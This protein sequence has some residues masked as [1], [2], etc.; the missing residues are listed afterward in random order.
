MNAQQRALSTAYARH[1]QSQ[2]NLLRNAMHRGIGAA[3]IAGAGLAAHYG[4]LPAGGASKR[5]RTDD[6]D[7]PDLEEFGR[8]SQDSQVP[9]SQGLP[10]LGSLGSL[11]QNQVSQAG[12]GGGGD[13]GTPGGGSNQGAGPAPNTQ[14]SYNEGSNTFTYRH[15]GSFHISD[16]GQHNTWTPVPWEFPRLWIQNEEI[17]EAWKNYRYYRTKSVTIKFKNP[18]QRYR[19]TQATG[20]INTHSDPNAR[21]LVAYDEGCNHGVPFFTD[22]QEEDWNAFRRA[23]QFGGFDRNTNSAY[24]L[25]KAV[26]LDSLQANQEMMRYPLSDF[27]AGC[28]EIQVGLGQI[29]SKTYTPTE[30]SWRSIE[31]L[32]HSP[33]F[34]YNNAGVRQALVSPQDLLNDVVYLGQATTTYLIPWRADNYGCWRYNTAATGPTGNADNDD[35]PVWSMYR[36]DFAQGMSSINSTT[37]VPQYYTKFYYPIP[38]LLNQGMI[39]G[40]GNPSY[41][42]RLLAN[43]CEEEEPQPML[44]VSYR[45]MITNDGTS[46]MDQKILLDFEYEWTIECSGK[47]FPK[48][49]TM[50]NMTHNDNLPPQ[51]DQDS[52]TP[53]CTFKHHPT[54]LGTTKWLAYPEYPIFAMMNAADRSSANNWEA[55]MPGGTKCWRTH[56]NIFKIYGQPV[57]DPSKEAE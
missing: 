3:A 33:G 36:P 17:K 18:Y 51:Y 57:V 43:P 23:T 37:T 52:I 7:T 35:C 44:W 55:H 10:S 32:V 8:M 22:W 54:L 4:R 20:N 56:T 49:N 45:N 14:S 40:G 47:I 9:Q 16:N 26:D 48:H 30:K 11:F 28:E 19:F 42:R 27:V 12:A 6:L 53:A 25:P 29:Y 50:V 24:V 39:E 5:A 34:Q 15:H 21:L 13:G 38:I 41:A 46:P 31:E 1:P 2:H